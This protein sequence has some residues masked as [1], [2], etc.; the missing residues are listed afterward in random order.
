TDH[1]PVT[2]TGVFGATAEEAVARLGS[3]LIPLEVISPPLP[4][5]DLELVNELV[6]VLRAA[7]AKGT[8]DSVVNAFGLQF[9]PE[10]PATDAVTIKHCLQ[11]FVCLYDWLAPRACSD[12]LR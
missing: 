5:S 7:G 8:S 12:L 6:A 1:D 9:N 4:L 11:A 3:N 10:V 2:L